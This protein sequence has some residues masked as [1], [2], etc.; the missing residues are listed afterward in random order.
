MLQGGRANFVTKIFVILVLEGSGVVTVWAN[1]CDLA[2]R[3]RKVVKL[4]RLD[5]AP[6]LSYRV[7]E[8]QRFKC[9]IRACR[10]IFH[11]ENE[12]ARFTA[13]S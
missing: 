7:T 2:L 5:V 12:Y 13:L 8:Q 11:L 4:Q 10:A 9:E 6:Y 3:G 1:L